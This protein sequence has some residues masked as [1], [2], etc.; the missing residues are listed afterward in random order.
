MEPLRSV[1]LF[2]VSQGELNLS[3]QYSAEV[4]ARVESRL[5]F[6]VAGKL[7]ERSVDLGQRVAAGQLLARIDA[8]DYQLAAQAALAQVSAAQSQRDLAAAEFKRFEA[9]RGQNFISAAE[10]ER[11]EATLKAAEATLNQ[12]KAQGQVQNNQAGY[13]R[14][15]ASHSGVITAV[16]AE[17][18]QVV[19]AG[20]PVLRLAHDGP[21]DAVFAVSEQMAFSLKIGQAMQVTLTS[22]G[23]SFKGKVRELAASADPVTR[24]YAVKLALDGSDRLPLGATL[25]VLALH[26][27]GSQAAVIKV[28]TSALRQD[29]QATVVWL[30]DET[31]MTVNI[32]VVVLGP[33]DGNEVVITS[34]LKPGQKVVSAGVHVLAPG[35]KVT[36]YSA[37]PN[38]LVPALA[39]ATASTEQR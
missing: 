20:Q 18:G 12:A 35:Q 7:V 31:S 38:A 24:T 23:Q 37:A 28:P 15:V 11:R 32:Q 19:S 6:Q 9:L 27:P 13:A 5:S 2:T 17:A 29:G 10:L 22:T 4:R 8:Q 33:I 16:E 39:P 36:V 26:L 14:L 3:G 34:G 30:L 1:K 25:N 21:R